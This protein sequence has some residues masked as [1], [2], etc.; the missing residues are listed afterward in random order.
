MRMGFEKAVAVYSFLAVVAGCPHPHVSYVLI[1][2]LNTSPAIKGRGRNMNS[3]IKSHIVEILLPFPGT[4]IEKPDV[5]SEMMLTPTRGIVIESSAGI[6]YNG[7]IPRIMHRTDM[8]P[9]P[10]SMLGGTS[11]ACSA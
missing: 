5:I 3:R 9:I 1:F 2:P 7:M 11:F 4:A 6:M 8:N 10:K